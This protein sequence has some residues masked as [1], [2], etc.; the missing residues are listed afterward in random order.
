MTRFPSL[1]R[2]CRNYQ[3]IH[4][5]ILVIPGLTRN[6]VHFQPVQILDAGSSPA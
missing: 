4:I 6:S 1:E 5:L 2:L 3:A